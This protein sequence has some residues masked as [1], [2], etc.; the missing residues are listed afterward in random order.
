MLVLARKK[1]QSIM[2]GKDIKITLVEVSGETIRLGIDAPTIVEI[3]RTE[4]YIALQQ[5]NK[6]SVTSAED[7]VF[8]ASKTISQNIEDKKLL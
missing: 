7:A 5:E 1:G 4:I 8:F 3:L 2:I 6:E